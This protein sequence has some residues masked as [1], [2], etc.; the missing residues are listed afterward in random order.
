MFDGNSLYTQK[1]NYTNPAITNDCEY[2]ELAEGKLLTNTGQ[3]YMKVTNP[4]YTSTS[5]TIDDNGV[6]R[7]M[8][9]ENSLTAQILPKESVFSIV[10]FQTD[11]PFIRAVADQ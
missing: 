6:I 1:G 11:N 5:L 10:N 4:P 8:A 3:E 2:L 7:L 9:M